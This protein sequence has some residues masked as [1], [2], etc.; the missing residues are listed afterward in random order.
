MIELLRQRRSIRKFKIESIEQSKIDLLKEAALRSPTSRNREPWEFVFVQNPATINKLAASK[1]HGSGFLAAAPLAI[2]VLGDKTKTDVWIEDCSI[3][4]IIIQLTAQSLG[5]GSCWIQIRQRFTSDNESSS[6]YINDILAA[7][8]DMEALAI[9]AVGY[10][11]EQRT[12]K[13]VTELDYSKIIDET[14]NIR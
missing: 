12:P 5:L 9:I 2:V 13:L 6:K 7:N 11:D 4:S 10:P 14:Y 3:A 8:D 1:E